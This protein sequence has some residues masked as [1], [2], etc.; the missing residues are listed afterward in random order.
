MD[1]AQSACL[2][3]V[4]LFPS[5]LWAQAVLEKASQD[6]PSQRHACFG[7][8]LGRSFVELEPRINAHNRFGV[9]WQSKGGRNFFW[10]LGLEYYD[11][12]GA[13][14]KDFLDYKGMTFFY[15]SVQYV[16]S[17]G[18]NFYFSKAVMRQSSAGF[19]LGVERMTTEMTYNQAPFTFCIDQQDNII[20]CNPVTQTSSFFA[21]AALFV[22]EVHHSLTRGLQVAM[23]TQIKLVYVGKRHHAHPLDSWIS[24]TAYGGIRFGL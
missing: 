14:A 13:W 23:R 12:N 2:L 4:S 16:K 3:L 21:P 10:H 5:L 20:I 22:T 1:M 11:A 8:Y 9:S 19:G 15:Q 7:A 6:S 18:L 24:F 17:I